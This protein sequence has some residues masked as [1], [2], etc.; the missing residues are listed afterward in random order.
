MEDD[1]AII[2]KHVH[3]YGTEHTE[4]GHNLAAGGAL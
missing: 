2:T 1:I 3:S 4:F